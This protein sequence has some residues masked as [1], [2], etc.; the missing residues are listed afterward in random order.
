MAKKFK[1]T[2]VLPAQLQ[3]DYKTNIVN[4][5]YS[6]REKSKWI[7]NAVS[8][9]LEMPN[10]IELVYYGDEFGG[11][12]KSETIVVDESLKHA[13]DSAVVEVR[14]NYPAIEG[15]QSRVLRTA[16]LQR[17]LRTDISSTRFTSS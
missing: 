9:L 13:L 17:L 10:Y 2:F 8:D 1:I 4:Q 12:D 15:V 14:K 11:F 3:H 16:I 5:G 7:S 6:L